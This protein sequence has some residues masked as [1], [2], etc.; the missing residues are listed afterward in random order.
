[1][2]QVEI[3]CRCF[4]VGIFPHGVSGFTEKSVDR[5][6]LCR[7]VL[8][9]DEA[10]EN[11]ENVG[12]QQLAEMNGLRCPWTGRSFNSIQTF[13]RHLKNSSALFDVEKLQ[14]CL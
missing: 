12:E 9:N 2:F 5:I 13:T 11:T 6:P 14:V 4:Q 8:N 1:V 10:K 3:K 7:F